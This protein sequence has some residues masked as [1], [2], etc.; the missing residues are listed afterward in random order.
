MNERFKPR[1]TLLEMVAFHLLIAGGALLFTAVVLMLF[2]W[3][4][5]P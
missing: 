3:A 5:G 4:V 2:W 1:S